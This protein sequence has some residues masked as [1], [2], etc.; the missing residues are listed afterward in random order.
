MLRIELDRLGHKDVR[1]RRI[2]LR[3]LFDIDNPAALPAFIELLEDPDEWFQGKAV[4]ALRRWVD[5]SNRTVILQLSSSADVKRRM[6]S[7]EL[8]PRLG[9]SGLDILGVLC[10]DA[11][12]TVR[13]DA[14]RGRLKFDAGSI[15]VGVEDEDHIVRRMAVERSGDE[16]LLRGALDDAHSRVVAAAERRLSTLGFEMEIDPIALCS[17]PS[18]KNRKML[19]E[20]LEEVDWAAQAPLLDAI[21]SSPDSMLLP[22]LLRS[23]RGSAYDDMRLSLLCGEDAMVI[24]R[25][26]EHL[27]GRPVSIE[28]QSRLADLSAA[29]DPLIRQAAASLLDD[30]AALEADA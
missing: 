30:V 22:R 14:W 24:S 19:S 4:D 13:R 27:H 8:A 3:R 16:T 2:A 18:A 7:A 15:P 25:V 10:G 26:L 23:K 21:E 29:E 17:E 9:S 1:Q 6:L 12:A 11:D 5:D 28:I 20:V